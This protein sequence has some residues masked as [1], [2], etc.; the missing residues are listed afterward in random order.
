M[1]IL[2]YFFIGVAFT[3]FID[4]MLYTLK[5][6]QKE[7]K[8]AHSSWGHPQRFW[9]MVLWPITSLYF[10]YCLIKMFFR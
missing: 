6:K 4:C 2:N 3:F 5:E 9:C 1:S 7:I 8:K 10:L